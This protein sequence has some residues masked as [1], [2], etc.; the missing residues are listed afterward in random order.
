MVEAWAEVFEGAPYSDWGADGASADAYA[1][2]NVLLQCTGSHAERLRAY[3]AEVLGL[4]TLAVLLPVGGGAKSGKGVRVL[5]VHAPRPSELFAALRADPNV[6]RVVQRW[7]PLPRRH[8]TLADAFAAVAA[9]L[10]DARGA[11]GAAVAVR[12][13]AAAAAGA[14]AG[15]R[16]LAASGV[17]VP[18]PQGAERRCAPPLRSAGIW[19]AS[20]RRRRCSRRGALAEKE[21]AA[22]EISR[23]YFKLREA[24]VRCG[25]STLGAVRH[26]VD[27]GAAPGG[28]SA[29]LLPPP[30]A[31]RA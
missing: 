21:A 31:R 13:H 7:Y 3:L 17:A 10:R 18:T 15:A 25:I 1:R 22:A 28:W 19:S 20:R 4:E 30:R 14:P 8:A 16:A 2:G 11:D 26:A 6:A 24:C 9:E 27:V 5:L 29:Y 12:V 23:A